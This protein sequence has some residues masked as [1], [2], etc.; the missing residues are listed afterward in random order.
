MGIWSFY[1]IVKIILFY[2]GYIDFHFFANL[3]FA[4]GIIF[5][6]VNPRLLQIR[7]WISVPIAIVLLYFDSQLP[8]LRSI[9]PKLNQLLDFSFQYYLELFMRVV[10]WEVVAILLALSIAYYLLSKKLRM[11]TIAVIGI[12]SVLVPLKATVLPLAYDSDSQ[13]IGLPSD[14]ELTESLDGFFIEESSRTAF[15]LSQKAIGAPF[16]ILVINVCSLAWDDLKHIKE[17]NNPLFQRF[18]YLFTNFNSASTYSGPSIIRL[19]RASHGQQD[20]RDLYKAANENA[21]LFNNL[22][23]KGYHVELALNHDGKFGN[24]L[25]EIRNEGGMAAPLFDNS[26]ATPY[27]KSFDGS[28]IYDDYAVLSN[29]WDARM[30]LPNERVALFYNTISLHDGNRA[31]DGGKAK[32]SVDA[33]SQRTHK[34]LSDIDRFYTK[35]NGSGRQVMLVFV[36]EHGA[37]IRRTKNEI[38][39][40]REIPS[41]NVTIIPVGIMFTNKV[42]AP[43]KTNL[44][45]QPTSYLAI[46][47]L[48]SK[49]IEKPPFGMATPSPENYLKNIPITRFVAENEDSVILKLGGSYY[50]RSN[51][52][53]WNLFEPNN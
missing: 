14:I 11:S 26:K 21:L 7:K 51:N 10:R 52:I 31:L 49:S 43:V 27:L 36:P 9:I 17:E 30:K 39:G 1:F 13:V 45:E 34:L 35:L 8:A 33:Y 40:M 15:N 5:S 16:D 47:D 50:F 18:Q 6:N 3:A 24:L 28:Q 37:A 41:P 46:S 25:K 53:N 12:L 19:L 42:N 32:N 4:L 29:W 23:R 38:E 22:N 48:I 44:I 20:Q 2:A